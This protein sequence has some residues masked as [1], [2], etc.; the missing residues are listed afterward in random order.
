[1][2][3]I[4]GKV[5]S[6][7]R[8]GK[9]LKIEDTW[10]KGS[11]ST[12]SAVEWKDEVEAEVEGDTVVGIKKTGSAP[13]EA[14]RAQGNN[15]VQSAIIFQSSRKDA[16]QVVSA[17]L[18]GGLLPLPT[19]QAD[20]YDAF[21]ALVNDLTDKYYEDAMVVQGTGGLPSREGE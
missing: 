18:A 5:T 7:R 9:G 6:K 13:Q 16:T 14:P 17:A 2:T 15:N 19:K 3:T 11:Q 4:T 1:M 12:L 20:K 21:L 10:Y 8:D